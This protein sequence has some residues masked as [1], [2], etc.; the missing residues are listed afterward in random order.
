MP[1]RS[2]RDQNVFRKRLKIPPEMNGISRYLTM[3]NR[4]KYLLLGP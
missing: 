1:A 3:P 4:N 2:Y